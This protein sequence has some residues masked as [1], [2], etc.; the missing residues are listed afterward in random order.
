METEVFELCP[1]CGLE[2]H[3]FWD[4]EA[5]GYKAYCPNCG[6]RLMLCDECMHGHGNDC[7][8]CDYDTAEYFQRDTSARGVFLRSRLRDALGREHRRQ[9]RYRDKSVK[10][11]LLCDG[12]GDTAQIAGGVGKIS[13]SRER[14]LLSLSAWEF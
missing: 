3:L 13:R 9:D 14:I 1:H 8:S 2:A 11:A 5:D 12:F 6:K 4:I 7:G 10:T